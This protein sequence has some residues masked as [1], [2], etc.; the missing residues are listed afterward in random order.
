MVPTNSYSA[1]TPFGGKPE[2][3]EIGFREMTWKLLA[4]EI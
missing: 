1:P 3:P 4:P 2:M